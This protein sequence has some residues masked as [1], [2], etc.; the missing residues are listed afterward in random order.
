MAKQVPWYFHLAK[1]VPPALIKWGMGKIA[2]TPGLGTRDWIKKRNET[3]IAAYFGSF[4]AW[5]S[6]PEWKV[7][8]KGRPSE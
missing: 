5:Q 1:I 4:E 8:L 2:Q 3:R 6:I 7:L